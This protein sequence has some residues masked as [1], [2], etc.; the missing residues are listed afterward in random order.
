[1]SLVAA[2]TTI[3]GRLF[4]EEVSMRIRIATAALAIIAAP[5]GHLAAPMPQQPKAYT[6]DWV[7]SG[8]PIPMNMHL[9]KDEEKQR[10]DMEMPTMSPGTMQFYMCPQSTIVRPDLKK[11]FIVS[12]VKKSYEEKDF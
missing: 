7:M 3:I 2:G 1:M 12:H 8:S 9:S 6:A 4:D 10:I 11:V 5:T